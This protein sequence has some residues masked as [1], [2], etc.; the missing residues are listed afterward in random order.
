MTEPMR[1]TKLGFVDLYCHFSAAVQPSLMKT[2]F[3]DQ[4]LQIATMDHKVATTRGLQV[5]NRL[6]VSFRFS[7]EGLGFVII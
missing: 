5:G 1:Y 2:H 4:H 3:V 7:F 6:L